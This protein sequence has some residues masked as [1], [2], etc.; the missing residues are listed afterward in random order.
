MPPPPGIVKILGEGSSS[1]FVARMFFGLLEVREVLY[2]GSVKPESRAEAL[3]HF[4][5]RFNPVWE[6]ARATRDAALEIAGL[7]TRHRDALRYGSA[8]HL[9]ANQFEV[10]ESIDSSLGQAVD[11]LIDQGMV[12]V[13]SGLQGLLRDPLELDI[14]FLFKKDSQFRAGL[15]SMAGAGENQFT[16][17]LEQV[18]EVWLKRFGELRVAHEHQ[19]WTLDPVR[20]QLADSR[21]I[22][23]LPEVLGLPADRFATLH[24][25]RVLLLIENATVYAMQRFCRLPLVVVEIPKELRD[26]LYP[27]RFRIAPRGL[28]TSPEWT[29]SYSD[30]QEYL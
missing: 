10:G 21:V 14:G 5:L 30:D 27:K 25:N 29:V 8:V 7:V 16:M 17:Y 22:V 28:A 11:K 26:H 3:A 2:L 15:E 24:A 23:T 18:R 1:P 6:A 4:D 12:A 20:Y 9:S 19:G 13:K